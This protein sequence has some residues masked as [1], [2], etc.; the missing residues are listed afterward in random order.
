MNRFKFQAVVDF[1]IDADEAA[2]LLSDPEPNAAM[3]DY[4]A[5]RHNAVPRS[6][7]G[8][9]IGTHIADQVR[10]GLGEFLAE[11]KIAEQKQLP[12]STGGGS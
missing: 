8:L 7:L 5:T 12:V 11:R 9:Y 10:K 1:E 6:Q 4:M 3:I 2:H